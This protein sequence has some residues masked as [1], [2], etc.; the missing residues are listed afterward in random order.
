MC[1]FFLIH[2]LVHSFFYILNMRVKLNTFILVSQHEIYIICETDSAYF[3]ASRMKQL[4]LY[5]MLIACAKVEKN[6]KF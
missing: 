4:V 5:L 3:T 2:V 6:V 1:I